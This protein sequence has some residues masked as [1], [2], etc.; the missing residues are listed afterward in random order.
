MEQKQTKDGTQ[1]RETAK[2][3]NVAGADPMQ[4]NI[5]A[6]AKLEHEAL[7]ERSAAEYMSDTIT[8]FTG[9]I[10]FVVFHVLLFAFWFAVNLEFIPGVQSFDPFPF[11]IL[12]LI[13]SSEG[14]FLAIFILI[15]QNR[16][17]RQA[18]RRAHLDL[19]INLLTEREI[20]LMLRM[21]KRL[22]EH[23][24][25][26]YEEPQAQTHQLMEE[27]NVEHLVTELEE[28]MPTA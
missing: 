1:N 11:G 9:S 28:K 5:E 14:V 20:T 6:I 3:A 2:Q 18:D 25:L 24:G 10:G 17:T 12:T 22:S 13:V 23:F 21:Q 7:H 19:Q 15:S 16:I 4:Y 27:M 26:E 8:R